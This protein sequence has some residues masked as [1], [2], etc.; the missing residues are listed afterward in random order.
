LPA[1]ARLDALA[2]YQ[3]V[4]GGAKWSAQ[5]NLKN[6]ADTRYIEGND[7]YFNNFGPFGLLPGTPR[8][9]TASLRVEF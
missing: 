2:R 4:A 1:Y 3:F 9:V 7:I 8:A 5:I 6:I